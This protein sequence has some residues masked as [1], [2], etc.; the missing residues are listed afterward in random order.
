MLATFYS[1]LMYFALDFWD[2]CTSILCQFWNGLLESIQDQ[3]RAGFLTCSNGK[4]SIAMLLKCL[5]YYRIR[6]STNKHSN[7]Y[8][9]FSMSMHMVNVPLPCYKTVYSVCHPF[10]A[11]ESQLAIAGSLLKMCHN[12]GGHCFSLAFKIFMFTQF[13]EICPFIFFKSWLDSK[14]GDK[15]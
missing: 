10:R 3:S 15:G 1:I 9:W 4:V 5:K 12:F 2:Y 7:G 11:M 13:A 6:T 14:T 8:D